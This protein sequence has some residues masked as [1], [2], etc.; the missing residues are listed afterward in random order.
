MRLFFIV[1]VLSS[2]SGL[3]VRILQREY[4][5]V[6]G[7]N[8]TMECKFIPAQ[9]VGSSLI[10]TWSM[11]ADKPTDSKIIIASYYKD[12]DRLDIKSSYQG[13]VKMTID[14]PAGQS[15]LTISQVTMKENRLWQCRA[16]I[17]GD[18]EGKPSDT[19]ELVVLAPPSV[20]VVKLQGQAEYWANINLTCMSEEGS[21]TPVYSWKTYNPKNIPRPFPIK[22]TEKNGVLSLFNISM[23]TSGYFVCLSTNKMGSA[24]YNFTL[25][26]MPVIGSTLAIIGGVLAG[27]LVLAIVIYCCKKKRTKDKQN[28]GAP[29]VEYFDSPK[30]VVSVY[31]DDISEG[32]P[33]GSLVLPNEM[34]GE[35]DRDDRSVRTDRSAGFKERPDDIRDIHVAYF[36]VSILNT[37]AGEVVHS[38][39]LILTLRHWEFFPVRTLRTKE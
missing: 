20:P 34:R 17:P 14:I 8:V 30:K 4:E 19:T 5:V 11:E 31:Q 10:I 37:P 13:R 32:K 6:L 24:S 29:E 21:P 38:P 27:V 3:D 36:F 25:A 35:V 33:E 28:K 39:C 7:R 16:Q 12:V 15:T 1:A 2:A 18:V 9:P 23:E 26:V 22:T